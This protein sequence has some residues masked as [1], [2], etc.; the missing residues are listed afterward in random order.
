MLLPVSKITDKGN[1]YSVTV[2]ANQLVE[3]EGDHYRP[4]Y[5]FEL[6]KTPL[7]Q[8]GVYTSFKALIEAM[9]SN[10]TGNFKLGAMFQ[11][12]RLS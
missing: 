10:P 6:P 9:K 4:D 11:Q 12:M 2:S 7:S 3:G 1:A 5:S 8:E